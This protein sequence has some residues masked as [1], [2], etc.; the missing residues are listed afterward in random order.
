MIRNADR[1]AFLIVTPEISKHVLKLYQRL[2]T[3]T[4]AIGD[5][6]ILYHSKNGIVPVSSGALNV[7]VFTNDILTGLGYKSIKN[8]LV[9]GSNHFP[10][11]NFFLQHPEYKYY[12]CIEDD[13]SFKGGWEKIFSI[14]SAEMNYDF[15]SSHIRR[16]SDIPKWWWWNTMK[17]PAEEIDKQDLVSSFNPIYRI[18]NA[19][20]AHVDQS[21]KSG[22]AGH[23]EVLLP[24]ILKKDFNIADFSNKEN[25]ITPVLSLCTLRTMR[26]KPVFIIPGNQKNMLYHPVKSKITWEQLRVYIKRSLQNKKEY[27]S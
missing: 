5:L 20:L 6:F 26:W 18:S 22:Y 10:V 12:W 11:L 25:N 2:K 3:A 14:V 21:L 19:A 1:Q 9:P 16:Y 7:E 27:F 17:S 8:T 24:T 13:V 4:A 23:H 15:I